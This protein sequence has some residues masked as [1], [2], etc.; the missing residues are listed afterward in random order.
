MQTGQDLKSAECKL[1][2]TEGDSAKAFA[3]AGRSVVGN[4]KY[5]IFPLKGKL[6][7]VRDASPKQLMDNE[8]IKN[9]KLIL[10]LQQGKVYDSIGQLRY[11][12]IILLTD[13]D[14]D[15]YHI[16]GLLLTFCI[17]SALTS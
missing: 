17:T 6:L 7:N 9:I 1:I 4:D 16:K 10:G 3:M 5:G 13:Q 15:G 11:G 8:E 12:G 14:V 2:L